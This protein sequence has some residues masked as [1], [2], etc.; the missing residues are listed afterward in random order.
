MSIWKKLKHKIFVGSPCRGVYSSLEEARKALPATAKVG[1]DHAESANLYPYLFEYTKISDFA[2]LF[3]FTQLVTNTTRLF[4]FGGNVGVL[5]YAYQRRWPWPKGATW[6]VCDVKAVIEAGREVAK[7]KPSEGLQFT[8]EFA[9]CA[10]AD[11]LLTSGTLQYVDEPLAKLLGALGDAAPRHLLLNRVAMWEKQ[12]FVT[13]QNLGAV[14]CPYQVFNENEL[15]SSL[16]ALGY[17]LV[18]SWDCPESGLSVRFRPTMRLKKYRGAY[19]VR[20]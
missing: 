17:R 9:D 4:D 15:I 7:T 2:A 10:G 18:D 6:M 12:P 20:E 16:Q 14:V 13:L 3:Y 19:L 5:Y 8:T 11:I 1:Y